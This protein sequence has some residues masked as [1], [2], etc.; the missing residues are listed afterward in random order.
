ME[1]DQTPS[2][3]IETQKSKSSFH[4]LLICFYWD[5]R[6]TH[7]MLNLHILRHNLTRTPQN[8]AFEKRQN[9]NCAAQLRHKNPSKGYKVCT[10]YVA[11]R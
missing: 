2:A 3:I 11:S 7:T 10:D 5:S 6:G 9:V 8:P 4:E 1:G